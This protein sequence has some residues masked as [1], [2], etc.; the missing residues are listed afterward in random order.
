MKRSQTREPGLDRAKRDSTQM[1]QPTIGVSMVDGLEVCCFMFE[2]EIPMSRL[3]GALVT[4]A[5]VAFMA[6]APVSASARGGGFGGGGG[7]GMHG[8][9]GGGGGFRPGFG[10][11]GGFRPGFGG[12]GFRPGFGGGGFRP[13]FGGGFR[14]GFGGFGPFYGF[15][16]GLG[17]GYGFGYGDDYYDYPGYGYDAPACTFVPRL[18]RTRFGLRR[19]LVT[20]CY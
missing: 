20:V 8:F 13:G 12:G 7:G 18:V 1:K 4:L 17:Y 5:V 9:G 10:G 19:R 6:F 3:P 16:Y 11:G 14:R 2:G 15:G